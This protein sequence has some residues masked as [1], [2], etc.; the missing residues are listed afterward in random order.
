MQLFLFSVLNFQCSDSISIP[1][2]NFE[3]KFVFAP[4]S[5][6]SECEQKL[7]VG[8]DGVNGMIK[9]ATIVW[10]RKNGKSSPCPVIFKEKKP[11]SLKKITSISKL[12]W[13]MEI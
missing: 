10:E 13:A 7:A 3:R 5:L 9:I 11:K 4:L 2:Y 1:H 8:I 12:T 6:I